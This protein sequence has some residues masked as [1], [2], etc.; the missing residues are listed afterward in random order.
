MHNFSKKDF[1]EGSTKK[2]LSWKSVYCLSGVGQSSFCPWSG[3]K[4]SHV[5]MPNADSID[6]T[7]ACHVQF[8]EVSFQGWSLTKMVNTKLLP[9][10]ASL[11]WGFGAAKLA[12]HISLVF[13]KILEVSNFQVTRTRWS[14]CLCGPPASWEIYKGWGSTYTYLVVIRSSLSS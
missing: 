13:L 7:Q 3:K 1:S 8:P 9:F 14:R 6:L 10:P 2:A 11:I 4:W 12:K 5:K